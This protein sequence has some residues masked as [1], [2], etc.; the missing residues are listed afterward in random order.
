MLAPPRACACVT[1][2]LPQVLLDLGKALKR[3]RLQKACLQATATEDAR[4]GQPWRRSQLSSARVRRGREPASLS[5][6]KVSRLSS[7]CLASK[8][9][10]VHQNVPPSACARAHRSACARVHMAVTHAKHAD[11]IIHASGDVHAECHASRA[12]MRRARGRDHLGPGS[13][14]A[15]PAAQKHMDAC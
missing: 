11:I 15:W 7:F 14:E 5:R 8:D 9:A 3:R 13:D 2:F 12:H 10:V 1:S 6:G 4:N